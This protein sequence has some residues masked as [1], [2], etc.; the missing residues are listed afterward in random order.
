[1]QN[2]LV[3]FEAPTEF[4]VVFVFYFVLHS[5]IC[6]VRALNFRFHFEQEMNSATIRGEMVNGTILAVKYNATNEFASYLGDV[7][8]N[9]LD[10]SSTLE[11]QDT[12]PG[13]LILN[14]VS[15]GGLTMVP[16]FLYNL[17]LA[18]LMG[19]K[20]EEYR[21]RAE[22]MWKMA[23]CLIIMRHKSLKSQ[24]CNSISKRTDI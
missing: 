23:R 9:M 16:F 21:E 12:V 7:L 17:I 8:K 14:L 18:T 2:L 3:L 4:L 20:G 11:K 22:A 10:P 24:Q 19:K 13:S 5:G 1:M 15:I 6:I